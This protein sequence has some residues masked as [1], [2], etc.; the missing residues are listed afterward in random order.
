MASMLDKMTIATFG[1]NVPCRRFIITANVTRE[2]RLPV[3]DEFYLRTLKLCDRVPVRRLGA[4]LG[5]SEAETE[6]VTNDLVARNL[7][8]VSGD[9]VELH[10]ATHEMFQRMT[11]DGVPRITQI[12]T[13]VDHVWFDLVS[14]NIMRAERTR[15]GRNL[16]DIPVDSL[17]RTMP[18]AYARETFE[19]NFGAYLKEI[20]RIQDADGLGLYSI[21]GVEP[22]R[23]GYVVARGREDLVFDGKF[24]IVPHMLEAD[25]VQTE[26]FRPL[27]D[28]IWDAYRR[29]TSPS[30]SRA[31]LAEFS[32]IA[33]DTSISEAHRDGDYF[34][35]LDWY[36]T[37]QEGKQ[38]Q[39]V[40]GAAY[41]ERN[42]DFLLKTLE[43]KSAS[44]LTPKTSKLELI[45]YRPTGTAWGSSPDL[46]AALSALRSAVRTKLS[47][48]IALRSLLFVPQISR[49]EQNSRFERHFDEAYIVPAG[50]LSP[51]I[52]VLLIEGVAALITVLV[53]VNSEVN[54]PAGFVV[55]DS[56]SLEDLAGALTPAKVRSQSPLWRK[57]QSGTN[58]EL[59]VPLPT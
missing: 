51:S 49:N 38:R 18:S 22:G 43:D 41:L 16:A 37:Q 17:A 12:D 11:E 13:W 39:P 46:D 34:D 14:R 52:E 58:D 30:A 2:R 6:I 35:V 31:A 1:F 36:A 42:V 54:V 23:F 47:K 5:L 28:A 32:H 26:A 53:R 8:Q 21:S 24:K 19:R 50:Y 33:S 56:K 25:A 29:L 27:S 10:P 59:P 55:S 20:R 4:F 3:V 40:M 48:E 9:N 45:W 7:V 15:A 44:G 57:A